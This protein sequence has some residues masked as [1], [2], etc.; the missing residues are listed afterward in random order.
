MLL[1]TVFKTFEVRSSL[2]NP[3]LISGVS[4]MLNSYNK[5]S[6]ISYVFLFDGK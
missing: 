4:K 2:T 5:R 1:G 6:L 3:L